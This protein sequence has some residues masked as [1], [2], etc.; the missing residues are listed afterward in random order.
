MKGSRKKLFIENFLVYGIGGGLNKLIPFIMLPILTRIYPTTEYVGVN[1]MF[2]VG[3]TFVSCV[4]GLGLYDAMFRFFFDNEKNDNRIEICSSCLKFE[5]MVDCFA[6][7]IIILFRQFISIF[8]FEKEELSGLVLILGFSVFFT[9]MNSILSAPVRMLNKRKTYLTINILS[10]MITYGVT[11]IAVLNGY[12]YIAQPIGTVV[13][14]II[15]SVIYFFICREWFCL[16]KYNV[17]TIK[18]LL[19]F[20]IP[21]VPNIILF[22]I[23]NSADRLMIK[24][25]IDVETVGIYSIGG[26]IGHISNL[27][28][29]AFAGGWQYFV[30]S[31][32]KDGDQKD[33]TRR[34]LEYV[35]SVAYV[36]TMMITCISIPMF[37]LLF[38]EEYWVAAYIVP[39]LFL[40]PLMLMQYQVITDQFL[41]L[42]KTT[43]SLIVSLVGVLL[44]VWLNW[45]GIILFGF[46]AAAV[47]TLVSYF[48]M[49]ILSGVL[50]R[51][52]GYAVLTK[53]YL[54]LSIM[55][56]IFIALWRVVLSKYVI[57]TVGVTLL[58]SILVVF[59]FRDD[60]RCLFKR[61]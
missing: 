29:T 41:V 60:L 47:S 23:F 34:I 22:W 57:V 35:S 56:I 17:E 44:N 36:S 32:M 40:A 30:F 27:I 11:L 52:Y 18:K 37:R 13:S 19:L 2:T 9:N 20:S 61:S 25:I 3:L 21:L 58:L 5:I 8:L 15:A 7:L 1:E 10:A 33:L 53:R 16:K 38:T 48:I 31:T 49:V 46:E 43:Y 26:K 42:K 14:L 45:M 24:S 55:I 39:Y 12:Y 28:Y 4:T 50:L 54:L 59:L 51:K 6:L